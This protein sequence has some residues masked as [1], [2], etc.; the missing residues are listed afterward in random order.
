MIFSTPIKECW[1]PGPQKIP[2][3][4]GG[5][6]TDNALRR[7]SP[8]IGTTY[9]PNACVAGSLTAIATMLAIQRG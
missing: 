6:P 2:Y 3:R 5:I 8:M 4:P 9:Y 7:E 1:V